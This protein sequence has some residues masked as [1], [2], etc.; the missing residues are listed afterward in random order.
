[1]PPVAFQ[2]RLAAS[3]TPA[4]QN[5]TNTQEADVDEGDIVKMHGDTL[6]ILRRGR[7]FTVTTA[8]GR[9]TPVDSIDAYPPGADARGD[10]Y[11][12]ML[13]AGD[14]VVVIGYSYGRG[15][16]EIDRFR[17]D[18]AGHLTFEDAYHLRSNDYYSSRN[19]A[20][21]LFGTRLIV[22]SPLY[23]PFGNHLVG[24]PALRRW[25]GENTKS[26]FKRIVAARQI[27][28]PAIWQDPK[29]SEIEALH[30]VTTC[31]LAAPVLNCSAI[32][33]LGP[34]GR[35]FYV[36]A[37]A[38]YVWVTRYSWRRPDDDL[39]TASL[40]YRLPLDGGA[41]SAIAVH[42]APVDQFSFDEDWD[43][44]ILNVLVR[45]D[46]AG[47]AMWNPEFSS[48][49]VS[50][51]RLPLDRFGDG[52]ETAMRRLYRA[53]PKG[54]ENAFGFQNRFVGDT[55][56]YG[57]G[58][59]WWSP[60]DAPSM[61]VV[62]S[63]KEPGVSQFPLKHGIDRIEPMGGHAVVIGSDDKNL[64][65]QAIEL[66]AGRRAA[67]GDRYALESASQGETRSH[68]FFFKPEPD[69][70]QDDA[71]G[72]LALPVARAGR[73]TVSQLI[74]N[75]ASMIFLRRTGGK[76]LPLGELAAHD[77]GVVDDACKASCVDWYG[78]ARPIFLRRHTFALMGYELVEAELEEKSI[79][80]LRRIDFAPRA[81]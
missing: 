52:S 23:M 14:R 73:P 30:T 45:N 9:L 41:P 66:T 28:V 40:L 63:V 81:R 62:A 38:V 26:G 77:D 18:G 48:G 13:I 24:L 50:L 34:A 39:A 15:G 22:Y 35:T 64:Y 51:L 46:G 76:F 20:S 29:N 80:E 60:T 68:A 27:Y 61:L 7:L 37:H 78:N 67:L 19:Y 65:F 69:T 25:T 58:N 2:P 57:S 16:T 33:V 17:I 31:D 59:S 74:E 5:I 47:D 4:A 70:T 42:G 11:D 72:V 71:A 79:R 21:R 44:G 53:L 55:L 32:S 75:T 10:W 54:D 3:E 6:V 8:N 56:L 43:E 49:A 1:M 12:E 36:S